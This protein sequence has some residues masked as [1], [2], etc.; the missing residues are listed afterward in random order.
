MAIDIK[1]SVCEKFIKEANDEDIQ[2]LTGKEVCTDCGNK[3]T[4]VNNF[5]DSK[6]TKYID[7]LEKMLS[8]AKKKYGKLDEVHNKFYSNAR[9]L[10]TTLKAE[11]NSRIGGNIVK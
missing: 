3:A 8:D 1:C 5:V 4:E 7:D 6:I 10:Q 2:R 9:S 11:I